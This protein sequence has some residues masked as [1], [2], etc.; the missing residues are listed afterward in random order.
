MGWNTL[1]MRASHPLL[2]G[3]PLGGEGPA[4]LFRALLSAENR[5][6][7]ADVLARADYGGPLTAIVGRDNTVGTQFHPEKSQRLRAWG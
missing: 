1:E 5:E 3:I 7:E 4:R 6:C 2:D